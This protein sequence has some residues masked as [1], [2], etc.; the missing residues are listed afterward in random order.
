MLELFLAAALIVAEPAA[1]L[2]VDPADVV[3]EHRVLDRDGQ[4]PL[5]V[6]AVSHRGEDG[7]F[8]YVSSRLVIYGAD[9][10]VRHLQMFDG[11]VETHFKAAKLGERSVLVVTTMYP[12]G[13][14]VGYEQVILGYDAFSVY[15]LAPERLRYSNMDGFYLG[16]LGGGRGDGLILWTAIW[17]GAHYDPHRYTVTTYRWRKDHFAGPKVWT[18]LKHYD[19]DPET[20]AKGLGLPSDQTDM[21]RFKLFDAR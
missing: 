14:G 8:G 4:Q 7:P 16:D 3:V 12:G 11:A 2:P 5:Q 15:A 9:C 18:T 1:C 10:S 21:D 13:S 6:Y 20:V 17:D 19:P